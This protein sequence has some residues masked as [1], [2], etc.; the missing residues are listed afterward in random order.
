MKN[1]KE[2]NKG[3][4]FMKSYTV[5]CIFQHPPSQTYKGRIINRQKTECNRGRHF[6]SGL[7]RTALSTCGCA[8]LFPP[9]IGGGLTAAAGGSAA[10]AIWPCPPSMLT[11]PADQC[12]GRDCILQLT[13]RGE[14]AAHATWIHVDHCLGHITHHLSWTLLRREKNKNFFSPKNYRIIETLWLCIVH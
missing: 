8:A 2:K 14:A 3:V 1:L 10:A 7:I 12:G 11:W 5:K 9:D 4:K 13:G 6:E